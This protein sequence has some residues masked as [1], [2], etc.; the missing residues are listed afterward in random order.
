MNY[1]DGFLSFEILSE[2]IKIQT[3]ER[4]RRM[5]RK[6]SKIHLNL[7]EDA[8]KRS[9]VFF[10]RRGGLMKKAFELSKLCGV[11]VGV[12]ITDRKGH[13]HTFQTHERIH[14]SASELDE[15]HRRSKTK[16]KLFE[17]SEKDYPF[18]R[19]YN[20]SR[21]IKELEAN[22]GNQNSNSQHKKLLLRKRSENSLS[23]LNNINE[24]DPNPHKHLKIDKKDNKRDP[25]RGSHCCR[26]GGTQTTIKSQ[27]LEERSGGYDC[28]SGYKFDHFHSVNLRE[29][30]IKLQNGTH[31]LSQIFESESDSRGSR[32]YLS[33]LK[34][35][36]KFSNNYANGNIDTNFEGLWF[37]R[38]LVANYFSE[39][40]SLINQSL[41]KIPLNAISELLNL[42]KLKTD[43]KGKNSKTFIQALHLHLE[44]VMLVI[45]NKITI[46]NEFSFSKEIKKLDK[47][48]KYFAFRKWMRKRGG[49]LK[50]ICAI[51]KKEGSD[52]SSYQSDSK[53]HP[54][55]IIINVAADINK[56]Q[57]QI[58][59]RVMSTESRQHFIHHVDFMTTLAL[60]E[61]CFYGKFSRISQQFSEGF[62]NEE[63]Q[64]LKSFEGEYFK[65]EVSDGPRPS[66]PSGRGRNQEDDFLIDLRSQCS[67]NSFSLAQFSFQG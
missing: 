46:D 44:V 1:I 31:K 6:K 53:E 24:G 55:R 10:R 51:N 43:Q 28:G 17:Y 67:K 5:D 41:R 15:S 22:L 33:H 14:L 42:Y 32:D 59:N 50:T 60:N 23:K 30:I 8:N 7:I 45:I 52:H 66:P 12:I 63:A 54:K 35:F 29:M 4:R 26:L 47:P 18:N 27:K 25:K 49:Y 9:G 16:Q 34:L 39:E 65:F 58:L 56:K 38:L 36:H 19:V 64:R 40:H 2:K 13:V 48:V 3:I 61:V 37:W 57:A 11:H 62:D 21:E 20:M